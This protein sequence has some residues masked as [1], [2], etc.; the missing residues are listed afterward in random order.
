MLGEPAPGPALKAHQR[1]HPPLAGRPG[2]FLRVARRVDGRVDL[3]RQ[4]EGE[5]C[6]R[7]ERD[8]GEDEAQAVG[9]ADLDDDADET[10]RDERRA[11]AEDRQSGV[12]LGEAQPGRHQTGRGRGSY[13]SVG[14]R[15]HQRAERTG[16]Q[17][18]QVAR[19]TGHDQ[20]EDRA[21]DRGAGHRP[22]APVLEPVESGADH[23]GDHRERR[24]RDQQVQQDVAPLRM[25]R[26]A[27]EDG[28]RERDDDHRV[29]AVAE[30]LVPDE[31]GQPGLVG[32]VGLA[33]ADDLAGDDPGRAVGLGEGGTG[34]RDGGTGRLFRR[35]RGLGL[36]AGEVVVG[37]L[38]VRSGAGWRRAV[39]RLRRVLGPPV[40]RVPRAREPLARSIVS[41]P[42]HVT[43]L[44]HD[45]DAE[46]PNARPYLPARAAP[47]AHRPQWS[48]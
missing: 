19:V 17:D 27:E 41:L 5:E 32:T 21:A 4:L 46:S 12:G 22:A 11:E 47:Q 37:R 13:H 43:I 38:A 28:A 14:L 18:E 1:R 15:Q 36:G 10:A 23:R 24:H 16:I 40:A 31:C 34:H 35:L 48:P 7:A 26:R 44:P 3:G 30:Y 20:G 9:A 8:G 29:G 2:G 6:A 33:R 25:G 45:A 42:G 39:G